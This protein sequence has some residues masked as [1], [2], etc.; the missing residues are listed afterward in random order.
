MALLDLAGQQPHLSAGA[1]GQIGE[2]TLAANADALV[3][4]APSGDWWKG[5]GEVAKYL[6]THVE[7]G[8]RTRGS[9]VEQ[10]TTL[11]GEGFKALESAVK[12][13]LNKRDAGDKP[14]VLKATLSGKGGG[15]VTIAPD[16][17]LYAVLVS[18]IKGA[19]ETNE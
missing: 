11:Y 18:M 7:P 4:V 10:V 6:R 16:S 3:A 14:I 1:P 15:S 8:Q 19:D 5:H 2:R 17:D 12:S 9:K 13:R